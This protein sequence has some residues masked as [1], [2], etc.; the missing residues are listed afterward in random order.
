MYP[1]VRIAF[2]FI[3][4][5]AF[6]MQFS[7]VAPWIAAFYKQPILSTLTRILSLTIVINSFGL[8]QSIVLTKQITAVQL[9]GDPCPIS[10]QGI[11]N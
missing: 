11:T 9:F 3:I 1:S 2:L 7:I 8:I 4:I 5:V 10:Y 6:I